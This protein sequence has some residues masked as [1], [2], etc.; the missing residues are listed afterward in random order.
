MP[1]AE[2][3]GLSAAELEF[4]TITSFEG[5]KARSGWPKLSVAVPGPI[6]IRRSPLLVQPEI[7]TIFDDV[8]E[9]KTVF[10]QPALPEPIS[11]MSDSFQ[12]RTNRQ[13][14]LNKHLTSGLTF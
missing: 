6:D 2:V 1:S 14:L 9:F 12:F 3:I 13:P 4:V 8:F 7:E 11:E 10:E 5:P